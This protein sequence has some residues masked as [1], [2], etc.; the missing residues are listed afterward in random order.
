MVVS[1]TEAM[2]Y[3]DRQ[4][5]EQAIRPTKMVDLSRCNSVL[6]PMALNEHFQPIK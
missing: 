1:R 4:L 3:A 6:K 2:R 5:R